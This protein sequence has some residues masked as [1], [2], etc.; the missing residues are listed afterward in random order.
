MYNF[1]T[2]AKN[3]ALRVSP[4]VSIILIVV[5]RTFPPKNCNKIRIPKYNNHQ[6]AILHIKSCP[7]FLSLIFFV[8]LVSER[9]RQ[10][11]GY[12][13]DG[14]QDRRLTLLRGATHETEWGDHDFCLS[15]SH[16]TDTTQPVGSERPQWESNPQSPQ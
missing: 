15:R 16:Y 7:N 4:K 10:Q 11:Q 14:S 5:S 12:I 1:Y 3:E 6:K 9:P 8:C 2:I 13:A